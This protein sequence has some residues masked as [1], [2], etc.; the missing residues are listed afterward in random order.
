VNE[1]TTDPRDPPPVPHTDGGSPVDVAAL[2]EAQLEAQ[3]IEDDADRAA[4][5]VS[6]LQRDF[7][8]PPTAVTL[9]K[10]RRRRDVVIGGRRFSVVTC[11]T[12]R[13][14]LVER[15]AAGRRSFALANVHT[16]G[17][18][19][20]VLR[21]APPAPV[22]YLRDVVYLVPIAVAAIAA[23]TGMWAV[24]HALTGEMPVLPSLEAAMIVL[25]AALLWRGRLP[26][27]RQVAQARPPGRRTP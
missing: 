13:P 11:R 3:R 21:L 24:V 10:V 12:G 8:V 7:S 27:F 23:E 18:L 1:M 5:L 6:T 4:Q 16:P 2:I 17:A 15:D 25:A 22:R 9:L 26:G 20:R 19:V 14:W